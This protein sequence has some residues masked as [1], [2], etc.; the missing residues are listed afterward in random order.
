MIVAKPKVGK[1]TLARNLCVAVAKGSNFLGRTVT[2]GSAMYAIAE[3]TRRVATEHFQ[4][5]LGG[6][7]PDLRL[8][9]LHGRVGEKVHDWL[10][11]EIEHHEATLAVL[12]PLQR[13]LPQGTDTGD[14]MH[15]TDALTPLIE[16]ADRTG[17]AIV[18]PHHAKKQ[19][20]EQGDEALGSTA[21]YGSV[22]TMISMNRGDGPRT[23]YTP[24]MR[25]GDPLD[26]HEIEL[27]DHGFLTLGLPTAT[28]KRDKARNDISEL[29]R[30]SEPLTI[31]AIADR[32]DIADRTVRRAINQLLENGAIVV[33][34][35]GTK[36]AKLFS[37]A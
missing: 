26:K 7:D 6:R 14:Y 35:K 20:G 1:S 28:T 25:D 8:F 34:G 3:G 2:S 19:G 17:C 37:L 13:F 22:D 30:D 36:G 18:L 32:T 15:S 10:P 11:R 4:Q 27:D 16:I 24:D 29:L 12:D 23:I 5:M 31:N 9:H 21:L 33:S